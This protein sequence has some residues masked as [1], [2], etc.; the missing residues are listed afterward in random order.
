LI[1]YS[2]SNNTILDEIDNYASRV[3]RNCIEG[4]INED[5]IILGYNGLVVD[6][7]KSFSNMKGGLFNEDKLV[8]K[9]DVCILNRNDNL[10]KY[11]ISGNIYEMKVS[12]V[13]D[14][15]NHKYYKKMINIFDNYGLEYNLMV[16]DYYEG[17]NVNLIYKGN[18]ISYYEGVIC[19][20][21]EEDILKECERYGFNSIRMTNYIDGDLFLNIKKILNKGNI[22]FIKESYNNLNELAIT[23]NYIKSR[24]YDIVSVNELLS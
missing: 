20:Y 15:V 17:D 19:V 10:D 21:Y 5:G 4:S 12:I 9:E 11:I 23:L 7:M 22:I 1:K 24:G 8:F 18:N 14:V 2:V 16:N 3:D 6:K 13:I